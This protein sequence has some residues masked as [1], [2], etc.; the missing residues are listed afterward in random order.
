MEYTQGILIDDLVQNF[1]G[2]GVP[3]KTNKQVPGIKVIHSVAVIK[4]FIDA[5]YTPSG[6]HLQT[7]STRGKGQPRSGF[8]GDGTCAKC[9]GALAASLKAAP[10]QE[11][12]AS[13]YFKGIDRNIGV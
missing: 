4:P 13:A 8:P 9:A 10:W 2:T 7:I 3:V 11:A 5:N 1:K 6:L 12:G